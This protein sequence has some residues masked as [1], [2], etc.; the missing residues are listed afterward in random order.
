METHL[1]CDLKDKK[2]QTKGEVV[3]RLFQAEGTWGIKASKLEGVW[4]LLSEGEVVCDKTGKV[5][6][7]SLHCT[8]LTRVRNSDFIPNPVGMH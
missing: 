1:R 5:G 8:M 6:R 2:E 7:D 3:G 4:S